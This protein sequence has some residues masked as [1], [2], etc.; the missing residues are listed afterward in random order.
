MIRGSRA[1]VITPKVAL[2]FFPSGPAEK[3][4]PGMP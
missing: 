4:C 3:V 2:E 1:E